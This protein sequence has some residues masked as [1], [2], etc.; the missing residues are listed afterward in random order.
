MVTK[1]LLR[2]EVEDKVDEILEEREELCDCN[3]CRED[4]AAVALSNLEPRYAGSEEGRVLI[5][6][7]DISSTQT[8]MDILRVVIEAAEKVQ[9]R[10][11]HNR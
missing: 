4:I 6:S 3:Q 10:P 1:N 2:L 11:H 7:I 8:K 5:D 9:D